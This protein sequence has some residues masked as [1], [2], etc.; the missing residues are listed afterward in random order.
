MLSPSEVSDFWRNGFVGP[1]EVIGK[2]DMDRL[3][4]TLRPRLLNRREAPFPES[5]LNYDRHLDIPELNAIVSSQ[6]IVGRIA[7]ILG[8]DL[9]CWRSEWFPKYPGDKGTEWHQAKRFYEFEGTPRLLPTRDAASLWGV[10]VW[11]AFTDA[12]PENGCMKLLPGSQGD[13]FFDETR[14]VKHDRA[15]H[16][17]AVARK[18]AFFGYNWEDLK[19]DPSW[20]PNEDMAHAMTMKAGQFFI[21]SSQCLHGSHPNTT[22]GDTR[23]GY[24]ARYVQTHVRVYPDQKAITSLGETLPLD[25]YSALLVSGCDEFGHNRISRPMNHDMAFG[26]ILFPEKN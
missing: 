2:S 15:L 10:T 13:W 1:Y 20:S 8:D 9:L 17:H 11:V 7:D 19:K 16:E 24:S 26:D 12:T 18:D 3:W 5:R 4:K 23:M 25:R 22:N 21:F 6:Q 14:S